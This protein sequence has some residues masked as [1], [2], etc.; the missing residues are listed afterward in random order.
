MELP[1]FRPTHRHYKGGLYEKV[2]DARHSETEEA[3]VVYRT[4]G[5]DL[6]VRPAAMFHGTLADGRP[7]FAAIEP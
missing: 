4:A 5:G 6:W 7:R 2:G 1:P 3:L